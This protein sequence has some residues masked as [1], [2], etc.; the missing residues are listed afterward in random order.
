MKSRSAQLSASVSAGRTATTPASTSGFAR[1]V[2]G[3]AEASRPTLADVKAAYR[4]RMLDAHP[5]RGGTHEGALA[6]NAA[7]EQARRELG[8]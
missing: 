4:Q 6:L 2:L 8:R 7:M 3:F 5:D 1:S